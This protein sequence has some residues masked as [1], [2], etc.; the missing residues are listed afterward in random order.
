MVETYKEAV[1]MAADLARVEHGKT[2]SISVRAVHSQLGR[3]VLLSGS[4]GDD[5]VGR[6]AV[7]K[8]LH[9]VA[10][11]K[12]G[13]AKV[14]PS[15]INW[16]E[17]VLVGIDWHVGGRKEMRTMRGILLVDTVRTT[18]QDDTD[19]LPGK[20]GSLLCTWQKLSIDVELSHTTN[21]K[22]GELRAIG[23]QS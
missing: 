18:A 9:A 22:V 13:D 8:L 19:R 1:D 3:R 20:V 21:E 7:G 16:R 15:G 2:V 12:N 10:D 5:I 23:N 4:A 17:C 6:Q 14:Q 11:A